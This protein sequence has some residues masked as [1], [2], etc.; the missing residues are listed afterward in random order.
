MV[1]RLERES[2]GGGWEVAAGGVPKSERRKREGRRQQG[3]GEGREGEGES[4][5]SDGVAW[6][7][8]DEPAL[9]AAM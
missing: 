3:E 9:L 4:G 2:G 8:S 6:T 5:V 7:A 1:H